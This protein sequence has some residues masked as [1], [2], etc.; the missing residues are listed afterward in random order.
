M[1]DE[2]KFYSAAQVGEILGIAR[3]TVIKLIRTQKL[4]ATCVGKQY[5]VSS[6]QLKEYLDRN[7]IKVRET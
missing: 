5:R 6:T 3:S 4:G 7:T 2:M 1:N